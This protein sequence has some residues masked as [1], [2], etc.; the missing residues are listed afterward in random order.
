MPEAFN[1]VPPLVTGKAVA[2]AND[3]ADRAPVNVPPPFA[4]M[5]APA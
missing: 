1:P 2:R 3:D 5:P 4:L